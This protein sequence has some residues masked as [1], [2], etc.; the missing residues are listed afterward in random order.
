MKVENGELVEDGYSEETYTFTLLHRGVGIY[1]ELARKPLMS[2][3][4]EF[5]GKNSLD[6]MEHLLSK[7]FIPNLACAS[8]VKIE[9]DKFHN[10]RATAEEFKKKAIYSKLTED[11]DFVQALLEMAMDCIG[12]DRVQKKMKEGNK[13]PKK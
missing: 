7:D 6:S 12:D 13:N 4:M 11:Y 2:T 8:Y 10:N 9:G 1:E 3:L 5:D